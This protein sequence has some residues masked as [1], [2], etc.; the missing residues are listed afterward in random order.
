MARRVRPAEKGGRGCVRLET[1]CLSEPSGGRKQIL[2]WGIESTE[3]QLAPGE[4]VTQTWQNNHRTVPYTEVVD[5]RATG[6]PD[7]P[8]CRF[9]E[10]VGRTTNAP[11]SQTG[12]MSARAD[13]AR[14]NHRRLTV[15]AAIPPAL[16]L[17]PSSQ[18]FPRRLAT[19]GSAQKPYTPLRHVN[20]GRSAGSA[21][22][23]HQWYGTPA[24]KSKGWRGVPT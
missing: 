18:R 16:V 1:W 24:I 15:P 7:I 10:T 3:G 6:N 17:S 9:T 19:Q 4:E 11:R 20:A 21:P 13:G 22:E 12:F 14:R 23:R 8:D 2:F 5:G